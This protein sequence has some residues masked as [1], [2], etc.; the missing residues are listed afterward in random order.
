ME[1]FRSISSIGDS[2][3]IIEYCVRASNSLNNGFTITNKNSHDAEVSVRSIKKLNEHLSDELK[4]HGWVT[5]WEVYELDDH[6][7]VTV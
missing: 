1:W 5:I 7:K 2:H 4:F 6:S 3:M